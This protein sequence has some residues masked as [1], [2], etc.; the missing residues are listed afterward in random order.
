MSDVILSKEQRR[1]GGA[2]KDRWFRPVD[3]CA[4][5]IAA[6]VSLAVYLAS[7]APDVTLEDS[8]EL[9]T[10]AWYLGVPHPPGYPI[11]TILSWLFTLIPVGSIAWRV[12]L[13]S[14][15][16]GALTAGVLAMLV[17]RSGSLILASLTRRA[18]LRDAE[19]EPVL[20]AV[21][22]V[23]SGLMYAF[24]RAFWSQ[25]VIAEVYT[26]NSFFQVVLLLLVALWMYN[27]SRRH[28]LFTAS[29]LF[30]LAFTNHQTILVM[31]IGLLAAVWF[32]NRRLFRD[33]LG[34]GLA[35]LQCVLLLVALY[36]YRSSF[37]HR[38][39]F[40]LGIGLTP[41]TIAVLLL[42][43][44]PLSEWKTAG[45]VLLCALLG[46][47]AYAYMPV[48]SVC[49]P[50]INWGY[51]QTLDGFI[52]SVT[53]GQYERVKATQDL[54]KFWLQVSHWWKSLLIQ[55]PSWPAAD[56]RGVDVPYRP[57]VGDRAV[58]PVAWILAAPVLLYVW[59]LK[60]LDRRWLRVGLGRLL[61]AGRAERIARVLGV[62]RV[63]CRGPMGR[64]ERCWLMVTLLCFFG[65]SV[66][67]VVLFNPSLDIQTQFI[68]R[69]HFI[70]SHGIYALLMGYGLLL[71]M[72]EGVSRLH[73]RRGG[74]LVLGA[75][76]MVLPAWS[77]A[78]HW[79]ECAQRGHWFGRQF[80][81]Y[82]LQGVG[83]PDEYPP[84]M[85]R[86]AILF[87]GTDPGR[88][89]PLYFINCPGIRADIFLITQNALADNT[90]MAV[91]RDRFGDRI[92]MPT[93]VDSNL[94]FTQ[95]LNE[96]HERG[97]QEGVDIEVVERRVSVQGV[98]G[99]MAINGI[100]TRRIWEEN[101]ER[102]A[103]Y[104]EESYV[105]PWMY[106]Y[107]TPHG[108]ILK[109]HSKEVP[110]IGPELVA[111]DRTF[112]TSRAEA[113][114][115]DPAFL[116]DIVA[117]KT[118]S[119]L[120]SAI[121][122]VYLARGLAG[123]AEYAFRQAVELFP[124]S[125]EANLRLADLYVK[126]DRYEEAMDIVE[127]FARQDPL[128]DRVPRIIEAVE[129]AGEHY[130]EHVKL[131]QMH[132]SR[133]DHV[134]V[135]LK[136]AE[137]HRMR[138]DNAAARALADELL[139][140]ADLPPGVLPRLARLMQ[141]FSRVKDAI[142]ILERY[143]VERPNDT[144]VCIALARMYGSQGDL[145]RLVGVL[146]DYLAVVPDHADVWLDL[147][148]V[149]TL[150]GATDDALRDLAKAV[151]YGGRDMKRKAVADERLAQLR[152]NPV[153]RQLVRESY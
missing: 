71:V 122:G 88:F 15:V 74:A 70:L 73:M 117:R 40:L 86:N 118:F 12:N 89:V 14:A 36:R 147:A 142:A 97:G 115:S 152:T 153:F 57:P 50:P 11:W 3:W 22:G 7:L 133:P 114:L 66:S 37:D 107:L 87:G 53:R 77:V 62:R 58:Y 67:L 136:L 79:P 46:L 91:L 143:R 92:W 21:A 139:G 5:G 1:A 18:G 61:D 149:K 47:G 119:K 144:N 105:I 110:E 23:A 83:E 29:F 42:D 6:A 19:V 85:E 34:L 102:H 137:S 135:T 116:R 45:T 78:R 151:H 30:G 39:P 84:P 20:A 82:Q 113:L 27:P 104:V 80:G 130:V 112:W 93:E 69:V 124:G 146:E 75:V 4:F 51:P 123:E 35:A 103:F 140:R 100:L 90:Y 65:V 94:A 54:Q 13:M 28:L 56:G 31:G 101:R 59:R 98:Q 44:R 52:H 63:L 126:A 127:A 132:A 109:L 10:A 68:N 96:S 24:S 25:A 148:A 60:W 43:R 72:Y 38:I 145:P 150:Q 49:N 9:V 33:V 120:R 108:L 99:V 134:D 26:L 48:A 128:N 121:G 8:G 131:L 141:E 111:A 2:G 106:P 32:V 17:S 64:L 129:V 125:P 55:F 138:G 16:F 41:T 76:L 95:Y 81:V